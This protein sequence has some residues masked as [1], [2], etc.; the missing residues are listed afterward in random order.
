M[1]SA[2]RLRRRGLQAVGFLK[3][4]DSIQCAPRGGPALLCA[5]AAPLSRVPAVRGCRHSCMEHQTRKVFGHW[6]HAKALSQASAPSLR[7]VQRCTGSDER[8]MR[9]LGEGRRVTL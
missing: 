1:C 3:Q 9:P 7:P 2:R 6:Q 8:L 4:P 5:S